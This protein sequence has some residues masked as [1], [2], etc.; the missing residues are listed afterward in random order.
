[1]KA[2]GIPPMTEIEFA[3]N[4]ASYRA[5]LKKLGKK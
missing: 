5:E 1:L 3:L 4:Q 2:I